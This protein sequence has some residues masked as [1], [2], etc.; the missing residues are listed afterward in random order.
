[1]LR[2]VLPR[3]N[4]SAAQAVDP[5]Y[6]TVPILTAVLKDGRSPTV[7]IRNRVNMHRVG[8]LQPQDILEAAT[9]NQ[10]GLDL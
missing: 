9:M 4:S 2:S 1:M 3:S 6:I 8:V 10:R 5:L 7:Q